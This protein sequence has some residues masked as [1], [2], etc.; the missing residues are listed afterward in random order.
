MKKIFHI[1]TTI[2]R[3]G[4]EKQ[5]LILVREQL[6]HNNDVSIVY[7]KGNPEL[8][9]DFTS[10]GAKVISD[11][12]SLKFYRQIN[13]FRKMFSGQSLILHAHLPRAELIAAIGRGKNTLI[14]SKHN[15]ERFYPNSNKVLSFIIARFVFSRAHYCIC[16]SRAVLNYLVKIKEISYRKSSVVYYGIIGGSTDGYV[17]KFNKIEQ[18]FGTVARIVEQKDY[19]TL[20]NAFSIVNR[21]FPKTK[22]IV[23]GE[24]LL[25]QNMIDL[26]LNLNI[27]E[28]INWNGKVT[29]INDV[30]KTIN[31][32]VLTSKYEGF[33][34][35]LLEAMKAKIPIL[36]SNTSAIPEVL[37]VNYPGLFN[38]GDVED[39]VSK[40]K[41]TF[42]RNYLEHLLTFY[43]TRLEIFESSKMFVAVNNVYD[44]A[45]ESRGTLN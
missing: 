14:I 39:L 12:V 36:A 16:I 18:V 17:K 26:A 23:T 41:L 28:N 13:L 35:V 29:N 44:N 2:E 38:V 11:L 37:G 19:P 7:L 31:V 1:I 24:G 25:K 9:N 42:D 34:L 21:E 10:L 27:S 8:Y 32:F 40:M 22:L 15:A 33:G 3:G 4:A 5:L 43:P 30:L 20:L 45:V 6:L